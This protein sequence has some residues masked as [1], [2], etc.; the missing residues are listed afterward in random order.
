MNG[1]TLLRYADNGRGA[2]PF[3][4]RAAHAVSGW[5]DNAPHHFAFLSA[6]RARTASCGRGSLLRDVFENASGG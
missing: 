5:G 6:L 2:T 4:R 3:R 1:R